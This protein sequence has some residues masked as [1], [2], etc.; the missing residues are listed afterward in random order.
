MKKKYLVTA[1]LIMALASAVMIGCGSTKESSEKAATEESAGS[2]EEGK[3]KDEAETDAEKA[4]GKDAET[5]EAAAGGKDAE[6]GEAT[7]DSG[8]KI[9]FPRAYGEYMGMSVVDG[10]DEIAKVGFMKVKT[11][12]CDK[13]APSEDE[14]MT[15]ESITVNG[16]ETKFAEDTEFSSSAEVVL[17]YYPE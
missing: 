10:L 5:G 8:T 17:Y 15:I 9:S 13:K 14:K 2:E 6:T 7:S 12:A 3:T 1:I 4:D 11:D 16:K